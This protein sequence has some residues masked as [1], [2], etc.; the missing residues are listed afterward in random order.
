[1]FYA[2]SSEIL[3]TEKEYQE[4]FKEAF[5]KGFKEGFQIGIIKTSQKAVIWVLEERFEEVPNSIIQVIN[6]IDNE[7]NRSGGDQ[8][9]APYKIRGNQ[10]EN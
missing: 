7:C 5:K 3:A 2:D 10:H 1:M 4:A 6:K 9:N 8:K